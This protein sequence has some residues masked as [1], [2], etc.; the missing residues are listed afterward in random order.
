MATRFKPL[1]LPDPT[2][3]GISLEGIVGRSDKENLLDLAARCLEGGRV[4]LVLDLTELKSIGGGGASILADFQ[5]RLVG[6]GGEA[7]FV[8]SS[9]TV[10]KFLGQKFEGLPLRFFTDAEEAVAA[11]GSAPETGADAPAKAAAKKTKAKK[12]TAK[13]APAG[14]TASK[15]ATA[16]KPVAPKKATGK[17]ADAGIPARKVPVKT[18][19]GRK[20]PA[21]KPTD[22]EAV[23]AMNEVLEEF[24]G[25]DEDAPTV[26]GRRKEHRYTSLSEA[27]GALGSWTEYRDHSEYMATLRNLLF[28]HGLAQDA[29]L[30]VERED[31]MEDPEQEW[32]LPMDC[33]LVRQ[34]EEG[35]PAPT[36]EDD[37]DSADGPGNPYEAETVPDGA[38]MAAEWPPENPRDESTAEVLLKLALDLPD[39]DDRPHF[40]RLFARHTWPVMPLRHLAFL[41]PD[42]SRPQVLAGDN[43]RWESLDLGGKRLQQFFRSM[44]RPVAVE[45]LPVFFKDVK[46]IL[47]TSGA[48]WLVSLAWED[49]HL[50]TAIIGMEESFEHEEPADLIGEL[51]DETARLLTRFDDSNDNADV[52]LQLVRIL[53]AQREKRCLGNDRLTQA[54]VEHVNR[55]ARVMGFPPDQERDLIYGCLLR[56]IG[57]IDKEDDLMR[58]PEQ[59]DPTQW[60]VYRRHPADGAKLLENLNLP[61]TIVDVVHCHHERFNGD[62]FPR[63]LKGRE[64]PLAAR[65]VTVVENYVAMVIGTDGQDPIKPETAARILND[66]LGERYDP[67]IVSV[68]LKAIEAEMGTA[69]AKPE[70]PK[71][72]AR[73]KEL[74]KV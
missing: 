31:C 37:P 41:G 71:A 25:P 13:K 3:F 15:K 32:Q 74:Q 18:V 11:F 49:N 47:L 16:K 59:M 52:N 8:G 22:D 17:E 66:N 48:D 46:K 35:E 61:R 21:R 58:P 29:M 24:N 69:P 54:I 64:I 38:G 57:L 30:L 73:K 39:A 12:A 62:G 55:L 1:S 14:K 2:L 45:N 65:V 44:E 6:S 40:W 4:K 9:D 42:R 36:K 72:R 23:S 51:F 43:M 68:F 33:S 5:R 19:S 10:K 67:D 26:T 60:P 70:N 50:G 34:L 56:D 27:V 53:V 28:S 7:V 63:G 20:A